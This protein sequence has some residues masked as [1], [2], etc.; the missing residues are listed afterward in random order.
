MEQ[1]SGFWDRE[2]LVGTVEKNSTERISVRRVERRGRAYVDIRIEW[3]KQDGDE[4]YP[5]KRGVVIP[6][7]AVDD[8]LALIESARKA[9]PG[10][11]S[12]SGGEP[13]RKQASSAD[14]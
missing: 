14:S 12:K 2:T 4:F 10:R 7:D 8:V 6:E 1:E 13:S 5:S 11:R 9:Q 3:R